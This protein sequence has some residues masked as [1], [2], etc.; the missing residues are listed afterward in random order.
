M[1]LVFHVFSFA[2]LHVLSN[3]AVF[4]FRIHAAN[5]NMHTISIDI[6]FTREQRFCE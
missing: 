4:M 2:R 3:S 5:D 6:L 1:L